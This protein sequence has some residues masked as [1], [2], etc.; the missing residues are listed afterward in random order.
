MIYKLVI[1]AMGGVEELRLLQWHKAEGDK[2]GGEELLCELE[3]DKAIVEV[4]SPRACVL[5]KIGVAQGGW[6]TVGPP[7]AWLSD[8]AEEALNVDQANDF[9]PRWEIV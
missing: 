3:T 7:L 6:A 9:M 2:I 5:R 1:P 8:E 4:R